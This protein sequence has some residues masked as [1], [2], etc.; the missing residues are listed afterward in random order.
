MLKE[1]ERERYSGWTDKTETD[2]RP[3]GPTTIPV[4]ADGSQG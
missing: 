3:E 4:G 2:S 1:L